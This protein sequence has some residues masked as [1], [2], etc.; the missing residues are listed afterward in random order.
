[1]GG[2]LGQSPFDASSRETF[3]Y[4]I[5]LIRSAPRSTRADEASQCPLWPIYEA[6]V[7]GQRVLQRHPPQPTPMDSAT[8]SR[9]LPLHLRPLVRSSRAVEGHPG[10]I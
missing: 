10:D 7:V 9:Q 1:M 4:L 2:R 3:E 8:G 5:A 6:G